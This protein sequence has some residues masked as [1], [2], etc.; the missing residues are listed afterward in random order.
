M[1]E[2]SLQDMDDY[3]TL[4]GEKKGVVWLVVVVGLLIGVAFVGAKYFYGDVSD[5]LKPSEKIGSV[6]YNK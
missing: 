1:S 6:P 4:K 3:D 5:D 2:P